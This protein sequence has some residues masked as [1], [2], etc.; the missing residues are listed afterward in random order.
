MRIQGLLITT[1]AEYYRQQFRLDDERL[2]KLRETS[3]LFLHLKCSGAAPVHPCQGPP[4]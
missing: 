1:L 4:R 3:P 2:K